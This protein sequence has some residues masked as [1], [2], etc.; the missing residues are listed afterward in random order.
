M[1]QS[2][3]IARPPTLSQYTLVGPV[4]T[5]M[6]L[7]CHL[8]T[9]CTPEYHWATQR[10]LA[11]DTGTTLEKLSWNSPT[12]EC[13]WRNLVETNPHWDATGETLTCQPVQPTLEH[14][15]GDCDSPHRPRHIYLSRVASMHSLK[16]HDGGTPVSKWTFLCKFSLYFE[17]TALQWIPV[18]LLTPMSTSTPL[19]T[20]LWYEHH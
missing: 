9:Q 10:I 12:L 15:W 8:L 16:W 19:C 2:L 3:Y 17:F 5:G 14:H 18:L 11:E 4:Y 6:P 7:E 1:V 13:Q 20:C